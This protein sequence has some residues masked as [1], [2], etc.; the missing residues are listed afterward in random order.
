M[1]NSG[2][3]ATVPTVGP[4]QTFR[5]RDR[6]SFTSKSQ[7]TVLSHQIKR[8]NDRIYERG[9][10]CKFSRPKVLPDAAVSPLR[11]RRT[12]NGE[13]L[14][15]GGTISARRQVGS[16]SPDSYEDREIRDEQ[17][18]RRMRL[19]KTRA[20]SQKSANDDL[21]GHQH[22]HQH[23]LPITTLKRSLSTPQF[24]DEFLSGMEHDNSTR[25]KENSFEAEIRTEWKDR[26]II[27]TDSAERINTLLAVSAS[28]LE[29]EQPFDSLFSNHN[30]DYLQSINNQNQLIRSMRKTANTPVKRFYF[31]MNDEIRETDNYRKNQD[32]IDGFLSLPGSDTL[33]L[34]DDQNSQNDGITVQLRAT[35][36]RKQLDIPQFSPLTAWRLLSCGESPHHRGDN[37]IIQCEEELEVL[38][39]SAQNNHINHHLLLVDKSQDSGISADDSPRID[40]QAAW[41]PQQ[42]LEETSSDGGFSPFPTANSP[43]NTDN[44]QTARFSPRFILSLPRDDRLHIYTDQIQDGDRMRKVKEKSDDRD[45]MKKDCESALVDSNWVLSRSMPSLLNTTSFRQSQFSS[46]DLSPLQDDDLNSSL[47]K[48]PSFSYL[49]NGGHIM[50]LPQ[51]S[52]HKISEKNDKIGRNSIGNNAIS[53]SCEDVARETAKEVSNQVQS[54]APTS[55]PQSLQP[56]TKSERKF[57]FQSTIRQLERKRLAEK[58]SKE[59]ETKENERRLEVE[60][61]RKAEEEFQR[62]REREK[63][64]IRQ[65]LRLFSL[66]SNPTSTQIL[67]EF[68]IPSRDYKEYRNKYGTENDS[69]KPEVQKKSMVHPAVTYQIPKSTQIYFN[70]RTNSDKDGEGGTKTIG[71]DNYRKK[72]AQGGVSLN[73]QSNH[74][75]SY[76]HHIRGNSPIRLKGAIGLC[77]LQSNR[78]SETRGN[79]LP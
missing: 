54:S 38:S 8:P 25:S 63:V 41:T 61:M 4:E 16:S 29:N 72:F 6:D 56:K 1:G 23:Q 44:C 17:V 60:A 2:S 58:L 34:L 5:Q 52:K 68:H 35:L 73:D 21:Q 9:S 32:N 67:S 65:Q 33:D 51:Y 57:T 18:S 74:F 26:D 79:A 30:H 15:N 62:K 19:F 20:E 77:S 37:N 75:T 39:S 24:H 53:K 71:V 3:T 28:R 69:P 48:Q 11:L 59:A 64:G 70:P 42:D 10:S 7:P 50:Y 27:R 55:A 76:D 36:P 13:I 43:D 22:F 78:L 31:G 49:A 12:D 45:N 14:H 40:S 66:T 46:I 47:V